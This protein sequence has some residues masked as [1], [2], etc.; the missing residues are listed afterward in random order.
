MTRIKINNVPEPTG[1]NLITLNRITL[2]K[3]YKKY[4]VQVFNRV[5]ESRN[6]NISLDSNNKLNV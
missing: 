5:V 1:G 2:N 3:K 6:L 4:P